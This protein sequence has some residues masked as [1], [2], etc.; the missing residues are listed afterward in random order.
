MLFIFNLLLATWLVFKIEELKPS[1]FE[2]TPDS[3]NE[4]KTEAPEEDSKQFLKTLFLNYKS[5]LIDSLEFENQLEEF[6]N[7]AS[8]IYKK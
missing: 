3:N 8:K 7:N 5:D 2:R 4:V 1:D 6:I